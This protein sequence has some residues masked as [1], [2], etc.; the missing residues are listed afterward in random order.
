L[1]NFIIEHTTETKILLHVRLDHRNIFQANLKSPDLAFKIFLQF[2][3]PRVKI[4]NLSIEKE[5]NKR[6]KQEADVD[7]KMKENT[8]PAVLGMTS[9][10]RAC[11][12]N[13]ILWACDFQWRVT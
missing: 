12:L 9:V 10:F 5:N 2:L 7:S 3:T 8:W 6:G 4:Q 13:C 11:N 1:N